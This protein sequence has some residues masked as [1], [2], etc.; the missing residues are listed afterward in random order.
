MRVR[1]G[2]EVEQID[3]QKVAGIRAFDL[4]ETAEIVHAQQVHVA[5]VA[6]AIVVADLPARPVVALEP[7]C[8]ARLEGA[9][10]WDIRMPT[11]VGLDRLAFGRF[12]DIYQK[13]WISV[14]LGLMAGAVSATLGSC[15]PAAGALLTAAAM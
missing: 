7:E 3:D 2:A 14:A 15:A 12:A 10:E 1:Q 9:D 5:D 4:E 6:R 13:F 8:V 11:I